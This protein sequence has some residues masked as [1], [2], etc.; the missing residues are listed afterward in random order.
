M[1]S[2]I[3]GTLVRL[4]HADRVHTACGLKRGDIV[5]VVKRGSDLLYV[6]FPGGKG[7]IPVVD[8]DI[9]RLSPLEQL[10]VCADD[11]DGDRYNPG[12]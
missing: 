9:Q 6:S 1:Y 10:A 2:E 5:R 4:V 3:I 8:T 7:L 11:V 12:G